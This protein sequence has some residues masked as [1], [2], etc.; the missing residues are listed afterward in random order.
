[1]IS[2]QPLSNFFFSSSS[3]SSFL[4]FF[5]I[6]IAEKSLPGTNFFPF[7][8]SIIPELSKEA[9]RDGEE[10]A[11]RHPGNRASQLARGGVATL[12]L[13]LRLALRR[14]ALRKGGERFLVGHFIGTE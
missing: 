7:F 1:M 8:F 14:G 5:Q 11:S 4:P 9:R 3:S 13:V 6:S 10:E 12:A 2:I